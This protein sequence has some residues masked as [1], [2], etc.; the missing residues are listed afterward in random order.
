MAVTLY[1]QVGKGNWRCGSAGLLF[2][3]LQWRHSFLLPGLICLCGVIRFLELIPLT[4]ADS[5]DAQRHQRRRNYKDQ[6][7]AFQRLDHACAR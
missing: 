1:R 3:Q 5:N 7:P 6:D 4:I 2:R